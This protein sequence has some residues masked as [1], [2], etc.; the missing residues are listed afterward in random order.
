MIL[1]EYDYPI[2]HNKGVDNYLAGTMSS[3]NIIKAFNLQKLIDLKEI[4]TAQL[5]IK[6]TPNTKGIIIKN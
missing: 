5:S 3:L 2:K 1:E 4:E 6:T